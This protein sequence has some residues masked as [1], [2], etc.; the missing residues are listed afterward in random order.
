MGKKQGGGA[1]G[2]DDE[3][4]ERYENLGSPRMDL[5]RVNKCNGKSSPLRVQ[6]AAAVPRPQNRPMAAQSR[7]Y[8][9]LAHYAYFA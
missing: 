2:H 4:E 3:A 1:A 8:L 7:L 5:H 9:K 6:D